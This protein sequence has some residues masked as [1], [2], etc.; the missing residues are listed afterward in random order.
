MAGAVTLCGRM[1]PEKGEEPAKDPDHAGECCCEEFALITVLSPQ[2]SS[3]D[4]GAGSRRVSAHAGAI[5][6]GRYEKT[7]ARAGAE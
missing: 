1:C 2:A 5:P 3:N 7:R 4:E 6:Q